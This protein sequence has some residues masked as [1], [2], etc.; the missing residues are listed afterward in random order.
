MKTCKNNNEEEY[1]FKGY[2]NPYKK[3]NIKIHGKYDIWD[4]TCKKMKKILKNF[5]SNLIIKTYIIS[6]SCKFCIESLKLSI[7]L[8]EK[9]TQGLVNFSQREEKYVI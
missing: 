8:G 7:Q 1:W 9:G 3:N 5:I 2:S 6:L 4:M